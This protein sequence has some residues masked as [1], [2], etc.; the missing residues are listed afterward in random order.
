[1]SMSVNGATVEP[2]L[3]KEKNISRSSLQKAGQACLM[4]ENESTNY[5]IVKAVIKIAVEYN[6]FFLSSHL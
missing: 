5:L 1:M 4:Q 3:T 2:R 6:H